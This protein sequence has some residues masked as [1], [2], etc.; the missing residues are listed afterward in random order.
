MMNRLEGQTITYTRVHDEHIRRCTDDRNILDSLCLGANRVLSG[1]VAMTLI[2]RLTKKCEPITETGCWIWTGNSEVAGYGRLTVDGKIMKAHRAMYIAIHG[3][4]PKGKIICHK[5]DVPAC[6]N[7]AHLYAGTLTDNLNDAYARGQRNKCENS[8]IPAEIIKQIRS[9]K[10]S[11]ESDKNISM[12]TGVSRSHVN[13]VVR[14]V[15][16]YEVS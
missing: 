9:L 10:H 13:K 14:N 6:I 2:D 4:V 12:I 11:G 7:P 15:T 3:E 5:C 8:S 16:R 1:G